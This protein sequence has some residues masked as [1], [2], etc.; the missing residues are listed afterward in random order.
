MYL[1]LCLSGNDEIRIKAMEF[2]ICNKSS[3][4]PFEDFELRL[5]L[6]SLPTNMIFQSSAYRQ[7]FLHCIKKVLERMFDSLEPSRR[8]ES[9]TFA[10]F[11]EQISRNYESFLIRVGE[12]LSSCLFEGANPSRRAIALE[13]LNMI[14][15]KFIDINGNTGYLGLSELKIRLCSKSNAS[16]LVR[17]LEDSFALNK[18][19]ALK[20]LER[21]PNNALLNQS[22]D[23][24]K[25][26]SNMW[27]YAC[28][29][30]CSHKPPESVSA[31]YMMR[32]LIDNF[33]QCLWKRTVAFN[34]RVDP[35]N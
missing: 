29:L 31:G 23:E 25:Y 26:V 15:D 11:A 32:F 28:R 21:F 8:N 20:C 35:H 6:C 17:C 34:R 19:C 33:H 9:K 12:Y 13:I 14:L 2:L 18:E 4:Q 30:R 3:R 10:N 16:A 7:E 1:L 22:E 24:V 5:I 27:D